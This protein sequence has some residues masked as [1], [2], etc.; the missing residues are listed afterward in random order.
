ME[1]EMTE[2]GISNEDRRL[3][4]EA[5][6]E[7]RELRGH[8]VEFKAH[9][10]GRVERLEKKDGERTR[11]MFSAFSLLIS[12]ASLAASLIINCFH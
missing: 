5:L 12:V 4:V 10:I 1:V 7:M 8:L 11:V 9:V 2:N 3:L 6:S